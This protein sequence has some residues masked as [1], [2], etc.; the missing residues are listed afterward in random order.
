M[1]RN[2]CLDTQAACRTV[3]TTQPDC[4]T[5]D[6][7]MLFAFLLLKLLGTFA[8]NNNQFRWLLG[9]LVVYL[10]TLYQLLRLLSFERVVYS[11]TLLP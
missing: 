11:V 8:M 4:Q 6:C 9:F 1:Y 10:T 5:A 3:E 2:S 7:D